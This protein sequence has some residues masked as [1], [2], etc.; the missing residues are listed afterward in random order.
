MTYI[1]TFLLQKKWAL[2]ISL[3]WYLLY[4]AIEDLWMSI[5]RSAHRPWSIKVQSLLIV[6]APSAFSFDWWW[7]A[8]KM[9]N[10]PQSLFKHWSIANGVNE[11]FDPYSAHFWVM[12]IVRVFIEKG[13]F[14]LQII[15]PTQRLL[16]WKEATHVYLANG[17]ILDLVE[18]QR[19]KGCRQCQF[20]VILG[21]T[22]QQNRELEIFLSLSLEINFWLDF[23]S[24]SSWVMIGMKSFC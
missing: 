19:L 18:A 20:W 22:I 2:W 24:S 7:F 6:P 11:A 12:W 14:Q 10:W 21:Q 8:E 4:W 23:V 9:N 3:H 5:E 16:H 13:H 15:L 1:A 17:P